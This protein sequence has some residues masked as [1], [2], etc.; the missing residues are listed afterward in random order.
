MEDLETLRAGINRVDGQLLELL[1]ERAELVA[2]IAGAKKRGGLSTVDPERENELLHRVLNKGA[3]RFPKSAI[4]AVFREIMSASV[5]LQSGIAVSFL[6]PPGTYTHIAARTLFGYAPSYVQSATIGGVFEAVSRGRVDFGVVPF[7]NST[8]GSVG[9]ALDGLIESDLKIRR[10]VV[11]R[12]EHCLIGHPATLPEVER[13]YSHPQGLAQ[14]R[15]WLHVNLPRAQLVHT[16]STASA[17]TDARTDRAGVAIG[18]ALAGE[19]HG[20]PILR[21]AI[22]D[23]RQN[24]TRFVMIGAT[25]AKPTGDDK[26]SLAFSFADD[27]TRG[28]L[29]RTLAAFDD[30]GVNLTRIQSRPRRGEP[31]RYVFV[32]DAE[33]HRED[34]TLA[35][36]LTALEGRCASLRV[37]GSYP[38][39]PETGAGAAG[40]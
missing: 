31:W 17:V 5:S 24:A 11:V 33:G 2:G 39:Y 36:A 23:H 13:V 26:T 9:E 10:E 29:R 37:L 22:Q 35:A 32:V 38:R 28:A 15:E 30:A 20:V 4:V 19:L 21:S 8:E 1:A 18:S 16:T 7:E 27:D 25:D 40:A 6:G 12:I 14:C 34:A 3:G